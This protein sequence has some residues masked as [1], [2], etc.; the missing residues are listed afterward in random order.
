MFMTKDIQDPNL[1]HWASSTVVAA[2]F[3]LIN[4]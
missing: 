3:D 4:L 2:Q 1:R